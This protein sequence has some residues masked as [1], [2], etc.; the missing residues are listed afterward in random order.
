M[1]VNVWFN[2]EVAFALRP[3]VRLSIFLLDNLLFNI[4][5]TCCELVE[6]KFTNNHQAWRRQQYELIMAAYSDPTRFDDDDEYRGTP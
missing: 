5:A 4:I 3:S 1:Y 2:C 6:S